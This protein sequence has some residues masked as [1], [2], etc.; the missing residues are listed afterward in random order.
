MSGAYFLSA[1]HVSRV[2]ALETDALGLCAGAYTSD[3]RGIIPRAICSL[4][5]HAEALQDCQLNISCSYLVRRSGFCDRGL[6]RMD[7]DDK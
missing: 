1:W 6:L 3:Y 4:F 5:E 7:N 2:Q